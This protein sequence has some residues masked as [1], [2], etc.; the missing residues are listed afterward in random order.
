MYWQTGRSVSNLLA[1]Q[2]FHWPW[3]FGRG[4]L[5]KRIQEYGQMHT[6]HNALRTRTT[7]NLLMETRPVLIVV[8]YLSTKLVTIETI[9]L[10]CVSGAPASE[11][12]GR[13]RRDTSRPQLRG[14]SPHVTW[15]R[16]THAT[17]GHRDRSTSECL[18]SR[19]TLNSWTTCWELLTNSCIICTQRG[20]NMYW[21]CPIW[22]KFDPLWS[23]TWHPI[24]LR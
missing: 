17:H 14:G 24:P 10:L 13:G 12:R 18:T 15:P 20:A 2:N 3:P 23:Q 19:D 9:C 4:H 1:Q 6:T 21:I 7:H 8:I 16:E 22:G 5:Y 11:S